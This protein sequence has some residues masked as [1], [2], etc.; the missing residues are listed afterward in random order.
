MENLAPNFWPSLSPAKRSRL[1]ASHR[2]QEIHPFQP[3]NIARDFSCNWSP[4]SIGF[5]TPLCEAQIHQVLLGNFPFAFLNG[6]SKNLLQEP[7]I[8][9]VLQFHFVD[10]RPA[11]Q[12]IRNCWSMI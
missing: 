7:A 5:W 1:E 10:F 2:E 4:K 12:V 6:D 9:S 11:N 8:P 3:A